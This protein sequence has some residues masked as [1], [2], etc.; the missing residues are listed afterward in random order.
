MVPNP[1]PVYNALLCEWKGC[2]AELHS[3]KT[4]RDHLFQT[5]NKKASDGTLRCLWNE[6]HTA[7]YAANDQ[8]GIAAASDVGL[9]FQSKREWKDH[10]ENAHLLPIAWQLGDGPKVSAEGMAS[11][12]L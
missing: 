9:S 11:I 2:H 8:K 12:S 4:L 7:L 5:H 10:V 3:R 1:K 6:C